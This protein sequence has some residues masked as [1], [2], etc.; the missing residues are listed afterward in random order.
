[1]RLSGYTGENNVENAAAS[2]PQAQP[3]SVGRQ[4][5]SLVPGQTIHGE[6]L[7]RNGSEV[8]IRLADDMVLNA[9]VDQS[10]YLE[11]GKDVTFEVKNNGS[12]L[13]LS[14]LF[15]NISTD[16]NV[17]KA[18]DMARLPINST[19]VSMTEQLMKAGLPVN[20][21]SLQQIFREVNSFPQAEVADVVN[22][23]RLG[24]P[25]N[26]A[27]ID[28]MISYRNLTYQLT[29]AMNT[30]LEAIPQ[31]AEAMLAEGNVQGAAGL[32]QELFQMLQEGMTDIP[33]GADPAA[34]G[35]QPGT[36]EGSVPGG[37]EIPAGGI[38]P[39]DETEALK[40]AVTLVKDGAS[41]EVLDLVNPGETAKAQDGIQKGQTQTMTGEASGAEAAGRAP[42]S[43]KGGSGEKIQMDPEAQKLLAKDMLQ[44]LE[45]LQ[46]DPAKAE[47]LRQILGRSQPPASG[48][49]LEAA[50]QLLNEAQHLDGGAAV[51]RKLFSGKEFHELITGRLKEGWTL[52]PEEVS[53][54]ENV[55]K[56]YRRLDT[57]LKN[58]A[59]ALETGGQAGGG[60]YKAV[61]SMAQNVDF[62]QQLNQ[63]Y[64]YVQ[65]PLHL[66]GS[67]AHGDLYV[68][69]NRRNLAGKDG[70]IS[71]LLHLDM[72]HLG[73]VDVY[74][75]LQNTKVSTKFYVRDENMLDFLAAHMDLLTQRL[76]KRGYDCSFSMTTRGEKAG[77]EAGGGLAPLLEQEK[78]IMLSQYAFDV[79][80]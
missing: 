49:L 52:R 69:T 5:Q 35:S 75:A 51:L 73:P 53:S 47:G 38:L 68:Y 59:Q 28:Q 17:L 60:A 21:N 74:V 27:N 25:V 61:T 66:N 22:L 2:R 78:G 64:A 57:Q 9:R 44:A 67:E 16:V 55:E 18:L 29:D 11:T 33:P 8:Q 10:I 13:T 80:T 71:A 20:R 77:E 65:L 54:R 23:H 76:Q 40:E 46:L 39:E 14:P 70:K 32:Y 56:L 26:Q 36:M 63:M 48:E 45:E 6:I 4:I 58:L 79:R 43:A 62:L 7:S 24:M 12:A 15:T 19:T 41:Q 31:A 34:E 42:E 72:K 50:R 1:M 37:G 3:A 30:V